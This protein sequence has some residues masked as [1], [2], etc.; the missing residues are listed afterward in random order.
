MEWFGQHFEV[1]AYVAGAVFTFT[2]WNVNQGSR[3][4][5]AEKELEAQAKEI[6][7]IKGQ[8]DAIQKDLATELRRIGEK[9]AHIEGF[10]MRKAPPIKKT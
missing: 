4:G 2:A 5:V 7:K 1:I 8:Q 9:L 6:E 3:L 10:L